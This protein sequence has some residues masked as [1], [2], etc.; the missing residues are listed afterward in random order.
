M[1]VGYQH[2]IAIVNLNPAS[3]RRSKSADFYVEPNVFS[4]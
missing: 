1:G 4:F 3:C 2:G